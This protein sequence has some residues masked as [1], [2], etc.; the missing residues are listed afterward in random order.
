M[1]RVEC[2]L[3]ERKMSH[4]SF[5]RVENSILDALG[6]DGIYQSTCELVRKAGIARMT[7]YCH[8]V[9]IKAIIP[10]IKKYVFRK[11][12]RVLSKN[13]DMRLMRLYETTLFFILQNRQMFSVLIKLGDRELLTNMVKLLDS[14]TSIFLHLPKNS[15]KMLSVYQSEVCELISEWCENGMPD[16]E[17][18]KLL[19]E[20][21]YLTKTMRSRL[22]PLLD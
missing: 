22:S 4:A 17:I 19:S 13:G 18:K 15:S 8:H 16:A 11:Y 20:I 1:K 5:R 6:E 7:F 21:M 3:T 2:R 12:S 10:D 14:R 9:M